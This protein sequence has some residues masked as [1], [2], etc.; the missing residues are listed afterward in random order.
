MSAAMLVA[1]P[2]CDPSKASPCPF[3][4][5]D[6]CPSLDLIAALAD[7]HAAG[8]TLVTGG[9]MRC[10]QMLVWLGDVAA[11]AP[12]PIA[13]NPAQMNRPRPTR[14]PLAFTAGPEP[15]QMF[16]FRKLTWPPMRAPTSCTAARSSSPTALNPSLRSRLRST[17]I[18][19][20]SSA[21]PQ[22][23]RMF[24]PWH[25]TEPS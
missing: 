13:S 17:L 19:L 24:A 25:V 23:L 6:E 4:E 2:E 16:A 15:L 9:T 21:E 5:S 20:A 12:Q 14:M 11:C 1:I 18:S 22:S 7:E 3:S 10:C 8:L